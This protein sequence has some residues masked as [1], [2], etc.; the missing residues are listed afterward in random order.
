MNEHITGVLFSDASAFCFLFLEGGFVLIPRA[1]IG[2][3][4]GWEEL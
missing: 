3:S 4:G 1:C 2:W